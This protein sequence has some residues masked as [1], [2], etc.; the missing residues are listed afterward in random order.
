MCRII[1]PGGCALVRGR[2]RACLLFVAYGTAKRG[3]ETVWFAYSTVM[4]FGGR[5]GKE[6][7]P[8]VAAVKQ[9]IA[10]RCD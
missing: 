5:Y 9:Q 10:T 7:W 4:I 3:A 2:R 1:D 8:F 6:V